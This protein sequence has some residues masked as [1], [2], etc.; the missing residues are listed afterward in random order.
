V[1]TAPQSRQPL[2][3]SD[4][5]RVIGGL[6]KVTPEN[7]PRQKPLPQTEKKP[8]EIK[9]VQDIFAKMSV[10]NISDNDISD[11]PG[12]ND[13]PNASNFPEKT[14]EAIAAEQTKK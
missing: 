1:N 12:W 6:E 5:T 8:E 7:D 10:R 14:P 13:F 4:L 3:A 2:N 9:N 11:S